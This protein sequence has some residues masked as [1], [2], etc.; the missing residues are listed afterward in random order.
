MIYTR[1]NVFVVAI[2][3][4]IICSAMFIWNFENNYA[5]SSGLITSIFQNDD[6]EFSIYLPS[7]YSTKS[8]FGIYDVVYSGANGETLSIVTSEK[9]NDYNL[10]Q[11]GTYLALNINQKYNNEISPSI[12]QNVVNGKNVYTMSFDYNGYTCVDGF[13]ENQDFLIDFS[14][15]VE[16]SNDV[17]SRLYEILTSIERFEVEEVSIDGKVAAE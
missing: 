1:R 14:Y 6:Y 12:S 8:P 10:T 15:R 4:S 17:N 5:A 3:A 9:A 16:S 11:Y 7:T 13:V 2:I